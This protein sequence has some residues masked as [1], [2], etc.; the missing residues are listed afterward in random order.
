MHFC[1]QPVFTAARCKVNMFNT[2]LIKSIYSP[3]SGCNCA[4]K[5]IKE[6]INKPGGSD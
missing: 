3:Q 5:K 4:V 6:K 2:V 1:P